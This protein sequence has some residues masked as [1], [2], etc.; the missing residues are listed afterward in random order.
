MEFFWPFKKSTPFGKLRKGCVDV[1]HHESGL[2]KSKRMNTRQKASRSGVQ[3]MATG[4]LNTPCRPEY[5]LPRR[6]GGLR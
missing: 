2:D 1:A 5:L 6:G 4:Q 3:A